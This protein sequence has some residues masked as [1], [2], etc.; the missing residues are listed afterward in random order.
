M[1]YVLAEII[2]EMSF[3]GFTQER[4]EGERKKLE[5][6]VA[7]IEAGRTYQVE[8]IFGKVHEKRN[9]KSD[10]LRRAV[11][12]ARH[13]FA[14]YWRTREVLQIRSTL[15]GWPGEYSDSDGEL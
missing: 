1:G 11:I 4:L 9:K 2:Y 5:E 12:A 3:F 6:A 13:R 7:D 10:E 14:E 8:E 15:H